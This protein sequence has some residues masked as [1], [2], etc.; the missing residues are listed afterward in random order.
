MN[1]LGVDWLSWGVDAKPDFI[2]TFLRE[3]GVGKRQLRGKANHILCPPV[4][5]C[6]TNSPPPPILEPSGHGISRIPG[7]QGSERPSVSWSLELFKLEC[8]HEPP[9]ESC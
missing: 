5:T 9:G 1:L 3:E 4:N 7:S 2:S 6:A 8:V